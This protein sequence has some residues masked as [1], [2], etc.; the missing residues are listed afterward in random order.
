MAKRTI[1][2]KGDVH[3]LLCELGLI[4]KE[5]HYSV[6]YNDD[7]SVIIEHRG[8][9]WKIVLPLDRPD[10]FDVI[11]EGN[12]GDVLVMTDSMWLNCE[13][14]SRICVRSNKCFNADD[15]K[16]MVFNSMILWHMWK[17]NPQ[18]ASELSQD[19]KRKIGCLIG[20]L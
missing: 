5:P 16:T 18:L 10:R 13:P 2:A 1:V 19:W 11:A 12:S 6:I 17:E 3:N 7:G 8:G 9:R 20:C 14:I 15:I 4:T